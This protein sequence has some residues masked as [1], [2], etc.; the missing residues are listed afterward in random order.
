M[1]TRWFSC[2]L[3]LLLPILVTSTVLPNTQGVDL[4]DQD[5][6]E[7]D[8]DTSIRLDGEDAALND[9]SLGSSVDPRRCPCRVNTKLLLNLPDVA[10][11]H[12]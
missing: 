8:D 4:V 7:N 12:S 2:W 5:H 6:V 10:E 11:K 1:P 9:N 3:L